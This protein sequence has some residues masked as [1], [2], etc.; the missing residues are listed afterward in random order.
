MAK[1]GEGDKRWIVEER[2]DE[3]AV[4]D[5]KKFN[6]GKLNG[7]VVPSGCSNEEG[8]LLRF[9]VGSV[10][11]VTNYFSFPIREEDEEIK[12]DGANYQLRMMR[13][14]REVNVD[15]NTVGW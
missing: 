3:I 15:N 8:Q 11:E 13:C 1:Y 12:D 5:L 6:N 14:L 2:P 4:E 10:L 7:K 9:D